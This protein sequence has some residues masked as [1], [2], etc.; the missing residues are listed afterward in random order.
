MKD[1]SQIDSKE[2]LKYK[3]IFAV[4]TIIAL[5]LFLV[6]KSYVENQENIRQI[7]QKVSLLEE[8]E[9]KIEDWTRAVVEYGDIVR[10][11]F[12]DDPQD[13]KIY[14]ENAGRRS[15]I[16]INSL[17]P[18]QQR[19]DF[20]YIA[21]MDLN[22]SGSYRELLNFVEELEKHSIYIENVNFREGGRR[23]AIADVSLKTI[24]IDE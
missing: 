5:T 21:S 6:R 16:T 13:F 10:D 12:G 11:F 8:S 22:V 2:A 1:L 3:N 18:S 9:E 14:V 15:G 7:E 20:Y 17:R 24:L 19:E 23:G 4:I